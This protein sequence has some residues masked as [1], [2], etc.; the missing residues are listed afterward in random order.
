MLFLKRPVQQEFLRIKD[1]SILYLC[2]RV[3]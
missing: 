1:P 2:Y 3:A